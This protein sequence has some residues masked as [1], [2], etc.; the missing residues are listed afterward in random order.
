MINKK[1]RA[2]NTSIFNS[3][4][5]SKI[6]CDELCISVT[7]LISDEFIELLGFLGGMHDSS[8]RTKSQALAVYLFWL[9]SG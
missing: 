4:K 8:R 6:I 9:K 5:D 1:D 7:G 2:R 3:F